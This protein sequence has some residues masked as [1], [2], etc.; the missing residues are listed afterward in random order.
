M[1]E[2]LKRYY[3]SDLE[4]LNPSIV[5]EGKKFAVVCLKRSSTLRDHSSIGYVLIKKTGRHNASIQ[6]SLSE[7]VPSAEKMVSMR[8]ALEQAESSGSLE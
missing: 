8:S 6:Q 1:R 5:F 4:T 7:G 2:W 3:G